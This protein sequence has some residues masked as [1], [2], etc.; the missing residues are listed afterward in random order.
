M[1]TGPDPV[2]Q[3]LFSA[4][5]ASVMAEQAL[6]QDP[7]GG[8]LEAPELVIAAIAH[9]GHPFGVLQQGPANG[10]HVE[11]VSLHALDQVIQAGRLAGLS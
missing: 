4:L 2:N 5:I 9:L 8:P 3:S 11:L 7:H 6:V 1:E 10:D